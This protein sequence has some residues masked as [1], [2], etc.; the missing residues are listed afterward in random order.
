MKTVASIVWKN[1]WQVKAASI[2]GVSVKV[3]QKKKVGD[4]IDQKAQTY[5]M[6]CFEHDALSL[7][8]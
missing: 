2:L 7:M 3:I 4:S 1:M 8:H 5:I 6:S